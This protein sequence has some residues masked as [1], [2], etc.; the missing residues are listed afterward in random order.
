MD[1]RLSVK[2]LTSVARHVAKNKGVNV[3]QLQDS[4]DLLNKLLRLGMYKGSDY[5][6]GAPYADGLI[7][8]EPN[9]RDSE[10]KLRYERS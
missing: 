4:I 6:L 7:K 2:N 5:G 1:R 8:A 3:K 9:G 10:R